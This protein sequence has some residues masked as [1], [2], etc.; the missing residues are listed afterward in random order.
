MYVKE[1]LYPL[2]KKLFEESPHPNVKDDFDM[3]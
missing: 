3:I 2:I 1:D